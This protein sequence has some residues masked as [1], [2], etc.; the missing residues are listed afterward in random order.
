MSGG[1]EALEAFVQ[2]VDD[3]RG[4]NRLS[5]HLALARMADE[6]GG[7]EEAMSQFEA[8][9][10]AMPEDYRPYL[11]M[12]A[13]LR[14]NAHGPEA[15]EVL[16]TALELCTSRGQADWRLLQELGLAHEKVGNAESATSFLEQ[17]IEIFRSNRMLDFPVLTATTLAKLHEAAGR[18]ERAADMYRALSRGSDAAQHARYH[19]EAGRLLRA[20]DLQDEA[21]RMLT[22]AK[23]LATDDTLRGEIEALLE[24][25]EN[26]GPNP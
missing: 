3:D 13:F 16:E 8:A 10:T 17:V 22:R 14:D 2:E 20:L 6:A 18:I 24:A 11:A 1:K 15:L 4:E 7:F 25:G 21:H 26:P 5:A 9:V 19:F 23:A 12:G